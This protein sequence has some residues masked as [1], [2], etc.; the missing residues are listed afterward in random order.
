MAIERGSVVH[1]TTVGGRVIEMRALGAPVDGRDFKVV[2]VCTE[3][4]WARAS[5]MS[6]DPSGTPWP[7]EDVSELTPA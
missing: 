7:V 5:S 6:D 3:D 1:V 4:E 2:W